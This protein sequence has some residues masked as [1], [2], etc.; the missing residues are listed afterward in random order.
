MFTRV[1]GSE[2]EGR[3]TGFRRN[4]GDSQNISVIPGSRGQDFW[5]QNRLNNDLFVH[6]SHRPALTPALQ[7]IL[8]LYIVNST[9]CRHFHP[10]IVAF[11]V[12]HNLLRPPWPR[13]VFGLKWKSNIDCT[14][15]K[16]SFWLSTELKVGKPCRV[17]TCMSLHE[18]I[19]I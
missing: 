14:L 3:R 16:Y 12:F 17:H 5:I 8:K 1:C 19:Y 15:W 9:D 13:F 2:A 4:H 6:M 7:Q 10:N 11:F 18:S